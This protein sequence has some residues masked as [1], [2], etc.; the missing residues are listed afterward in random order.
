MLH[1]SHWNRSITNLQTIQQH[2]DYPEINIFAKIHNHKKRQTCTASDRTRPAVQAAVTNLHK[3]KFTLQNNNNNTTTTT[4]TT[5]TT[6]LRPFV[7]DYPGEWVPEETS[8]HLHLSFI[9]FL[10]LL[11]SIASSLFNLHVS[12]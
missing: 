9:S 3:Q 11:Q 6:I 4:T 8:L 12:V 1:C 7:Q 2:Y 10:N 5:T